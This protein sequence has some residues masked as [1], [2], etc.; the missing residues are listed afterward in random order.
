MEKADFREAAEK[1]SASRDVGAQLFCAMLRSV[2][3]DA[4]LVCS[5]QP[6]PFSGSAKGKPLPSAKHQV[7]VATAANISA[8]ESSANSDTERATKPSNQG[9]AVGSLGGRSRFDSDP[10]LKLGHEHRPSARP[11]GYVPSK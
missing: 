7:Y 4:R 2:G 9:R 3:V 5:L 8:E 11:S 1:R 6:L 10:S